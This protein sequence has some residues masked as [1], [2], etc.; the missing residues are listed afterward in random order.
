MKKKVNWLSESA[1]AALTKYHAQGDL[2]NRD[3]FSHSSGVCKSKIKVPARSFHPEA[4]S[5]GPQVTT[6]SLCAHV[7]FFARTVWHVGS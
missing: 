4:A 7:F 1:R 6:I 5:L 2:N 3:L